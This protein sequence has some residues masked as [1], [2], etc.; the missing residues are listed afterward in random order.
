[1]S[2]FEAYVDDSGSEP[3]S[4]IFFLAGLVSSADR[5][6]E[7]SKEWDAALALP[8]ALD[9]FK[10]SEAAG[11]WEQFSRTKGWDEQKREDRLVALARIIN[12]HAVLRVSTSIQYGLFEKY[13]Q[14]LP[15]TKR[16]LST[17]EPYVML[18]SHLVSVAVMFADENAL[19]QPIDFVFDRQLGHEDEFCR[20]WSD[21]KRSLLTS[22][23]GKHLSRLVGKEPVFADEKD[24]KP[25]QAA[26]LY[27]WQARNH[28]VENH[29]FPNQKIIVP[30]N[31]ILRLF[32]R[33]PQAHYPMT[34]PVLKRQL[35]ALVR[36]GEHLKKMDPL[37]KLVPAAADRKERRKVRR[38]TKKQWSKKA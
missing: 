27:V 13:V 35:D 16:S 34:E 21:Y 14:S 2:G 11:F 19:D 30:M 23:R 24:R 3:S 1:M 12:R 18:A 7:F 38:Q 17:D 33:I 32:R 29:R 9:Y 37:L 26:D 36:T 25:L 15:A 5:W 4:K 28:Y 31:S 6:A 20:R 10:M 8:P 22:P